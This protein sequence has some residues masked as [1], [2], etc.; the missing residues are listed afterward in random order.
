MLNIP[1]L[2]RCLANRLKAN[3]AYD[4]LVNINAYDTRAISYGSP[5]MF[6]KFIFFSKYLTARL[7]PWAICEPNP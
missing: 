4:D 5:V 3:S 7:S 1:S 2:L 6:N